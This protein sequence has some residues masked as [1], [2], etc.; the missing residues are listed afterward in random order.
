MIISNKNKR[1]VGRPSMR[2]MTVRKGVKH[3]K[4]VQI[5][6]YP[7]ET[8]Y[9]LSAMQGVSIFALIAKADAL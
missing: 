4:A 7:R 5:C 6:N 1:N 3:G 2:T 9:L 8:K